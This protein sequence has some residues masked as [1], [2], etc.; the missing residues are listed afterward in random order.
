LA[1]HFPQL[2]PKGGDQRFVATV[3]NL[4]MQG[5]LNATATLTLAANATAT[6]F[7]DRRIGADSFLA[8]MPLTAAAAA[9]LATTS[10]AIRVPGLATLHHADLPGT[11]R[12]FGVLIIG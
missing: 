5:K 4:A 10:V 9:A 2:P 6:D 3:L 7:A 1:A 11:D 8:L 12:Q